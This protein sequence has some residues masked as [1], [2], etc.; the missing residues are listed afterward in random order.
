[1]LKVH[2]ICHVGLLKSNREDIK[3]TSRGESSCAP[4]NIKVSN[5]REIDN[6]LAYW[7]VQMG[8]ERVQEYLIQWR[9][10]LE[11]EAN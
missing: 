10:L 4:I 6:I 5:D 8:K 9:G 3:D 2:P 11:E 7:V 1:M